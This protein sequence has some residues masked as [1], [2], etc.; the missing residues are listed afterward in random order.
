[1]KYNDLGMLIQEFQAHAGAVDDDPEGGVSPNVQYGYKAT[2]GTYNEMSNVYT[3]AMRLAEVVYPNG[4]KGFFDY[5]TDDPNDK[6]SRLAAIKDD[7]GSG[8]EGSVLASYSYNGLA[9]LVG[10]T[11]ENEPDVRLDYYRQPNGTA[12]PGTY[13]GF[14]RFGR[15]TTQ[16]WR[17]Y[18]AGAIREQLDYGYDPPSRPCRYGGACYNSNRTYR[19][20][21]LADN[22]SKKFDELYAYDDLDRLID[23]KRGKL[24]EGRT[25]IPY[26]SPADRLRREEWTLSDTGN[27]NQ[28]KIDQNGDGDYADAGDLDQNRTHNAV[29]E[30]YNATA[31]NA[32]TEEY[33]PQ[34]SWA[35]P[36]HDS[37]GNMTT[38]PQPGAMTGTYTC[39]YD[40]WNRLVKVTDDENQNAVVAEYRYDGLNRRIRKYTPDASN[41]TVTEYYYNAAWQ[42]LEVRREDGVSRSGTPI[43]E[44]AVSA[45]VHEQYVWSARYIDAPILRDRD[46]GADG[47]LG[48][49]GSGLDERLYYLTDA[50]MCVTALVDTSGAVVERYHYDPYG[51][52]TILDG[53]TGD[54]TEWDEDDGQVSDVANEVLWCGY[55]RDTESGLYHV[56]H[57]M[58]HP[59]LGRWLQRDPLGYV[60]GISLYEYCRSRPASA[61]DPLGLDAWLLVSQSHAGIM[62]EVRSKDGKQVLGWLLANYHAHGYMGD[63]TEPKTVSGEIVDAPGRVQLVYTPNVGKDALK[64]PLG[65][66]YP[67]VLPMKGTPE[68]DARLI[69]WLLKASGNNQEWFVK[70]VKEKDP[71]SGHYNAKEVWASYSVFH[72]R[73]CIQFTFD[74]ASEYLGHPLAADVDGRSPYRP[75]WL[76]PGVRSR[77]ALILA[78]LYKGNFDKEGNWTGAA[79]KYNAKAFRDAFKPFE[80]MM[81]P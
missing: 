73:T 14:D 60:D 80:G 4:R 76:T 50:H 71:N 25:E 22:A 15:I 21:V 12:T 56:R 17:A 27:W 20:N 72:N 67:N 47:D 35:D 66:G 9:R 34:S 8:G 23:F 77:R 75:T 58:Y 26:Q 37:R 45:T 41:W 78:D 61:A 38:V 2:F 19:D 6:I 48:I 7:N 28:Y 74:A 63:G 70:L 46:A 39:V 11:F 32:I 55:R 59:L 68:Q 52:V 64:G 69:N 36:A 30:I 24:N 54:Q 53:T 81:C 51:R 18:T 31:G 5:G 62:V 10:E 3:K 29:N 42:V 44:P 65:S 13:K 49:E 79:D 40:A 1:M 57:R 33:E 16:A 43:P